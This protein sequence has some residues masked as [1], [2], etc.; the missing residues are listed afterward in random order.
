MILI[1]KMYLATKMMV[2]ASIMM[3]NK[4]DTINILYCSRVL[5][6][7]RMTFEV[8]SKTK[9]SP[10]LISFYMVFV[11]MAETISTS[12]SSL[13]A[14]FHLFWHKNHFTTVML[15]NAKKTGKD[16]LRASVQSSS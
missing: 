11:S 13:Q 3:V 2:N 8:Y 4:H 5:Y 10:F 15:S 7:H 12:T 9:F 1:Q 14:I 16:S 6:V